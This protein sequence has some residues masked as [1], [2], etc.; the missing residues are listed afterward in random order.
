MNM[1]FAFGFGHWEVLAIL[2]IAVLLFG[3]RIPSVMRSM[4]QG[5]TEFKKGMKDPDDEPAGESQK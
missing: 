3:T 2:V 5:I 1:L 4:G